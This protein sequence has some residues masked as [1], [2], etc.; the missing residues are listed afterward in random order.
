M[1]CQENDRLIDSAIGLAEKL[2]IPV[3]RIENLD[4]EGLLDFVMTN[5]LP[6]GERDG[7]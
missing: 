5:R 6:G 3:A 4:L 7:D 2:G 1:S